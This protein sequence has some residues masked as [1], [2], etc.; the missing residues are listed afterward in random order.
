MTRK[1]DHVLIIA[2]IEGS[3][4]CWNRRASKFVTDEWSRACV[5]M[6]LDINAVVR[7]LLDAGVKKITVKDFHRTGYNLLPEM[8]DPL[9]RVVLGYRQGPVPGLGNPGDA[10]A[11]MFLGMHAASGTEGFMAHTLTS[12]II[13][14]EV[15]RRPLA[16]VELFAASLAPYGIRP[17]FFSGC[18]T[19]CAQAQAAIA[20]INSYPI[21][22]SDGPALFNTQSWRAG[23][24]RGALESLNN[25]ATG[26]YATSG[27]LRAEVTMWDGERSARKLA[28]RWGFDHEGGRIFIETADIHQLYRELIRLCYLTPLTEKI[29][30]WGLFFYNLTGRLGLEWVRWRQR[31]A[32][33]RYKLSGQKE[34]NN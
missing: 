9:A 14:L 20:K 27:P 1:F 17:I 21:D 6:T 15:N 11:V 30:P 3:S 12:R 18:P 33:T 34:I 19:A 32:L 10:E 31:P 22:K 26:P 24:V 29:L 23:L 7:G 4:G 25:F 28:H 2:D 8:I 13:W 5:E 16:E